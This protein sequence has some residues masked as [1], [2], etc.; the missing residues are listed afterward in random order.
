MR[1]LGTRAAGAVLVAAVLFTVAAPLLAQ[2]SIDEAENLR[3]GVRNAQLDAEVRIELLEAYD[4]DVVAALTAA[5]E[6]VESQRARVEAVRLE[7]DQAR[8]EQRQIEISLQWGAVDL[9]TL[10]EEARIVAVEAYLSAGDRRRTEFV[11]SAE[12]VN[13]AATRLAMLDAVSDS[14]TEVLEQ[15]RVATDEHDAALAS[16]DEVIARIERTEAELA[17]ELAE[18]TEQEARQAEIKAELDA[19][20]AVWEAEL[21][22]FEAEEARLSSFIV[23]TQAAQAAAAAAASAAAN[24]TFVPDLSSVSTQGFVYPTSG[25]ISS[26]FGQR[27]HPILGYYR[28]HNGI[29]MGGGFGSPIWASK[30]GTVI[31]A[32]WNGGYGNAVIIDHGDGV[33]TLYGH[34][35][36]LFVSTGQTVTTGQRIGSIGSTGLSTGPH[37]HFEVRVGG[38]PVDPLLFMP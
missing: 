9:E 35:S 37:L 25:G 23:Q 11:L 13:E 31:S 16:V 24:G 22:S 19:R 3:E 29:D 38:T 30:G 28:M 18:L 1:A 6:L 8:T 5:N 36:E 7:L 32:G 20:I 34:Q 21:A 17:A 4:E 10:R 26:G 15:L 27:L 2:E 33:A 14:A 12:S